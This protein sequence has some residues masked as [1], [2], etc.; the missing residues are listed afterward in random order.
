MLEI[1]ASVVIPTFNS[2]ETIERCLA[3]IR[4]NVTEYEYEIIVVDAASSDNTVEIARK[5]ADKVLV[6]TPFRINRD[7]GV[8]VAK[9]DIICFT[10]SDC[11]VPEDWIDKLVI[12]LLRLNSKDNS[13]AGVGG[14]NI[15]WSGNTSSVEEAISKTMRSPLV[16]FKARNV[17]IYKEE[18]QVQHNPPVNSALFRWV[19]EEIGGFKEEPGYPEDLDL[20]IR[21]NEKGYKLYYL[22][23]PIVQHKHKTD[24]IKFAKQMYDF[25]RKRIKVNREHPHASRFYHYG[26]LFLCF[27]LYSPLFFIPLAMALANAIYVSIRER[28]LLFFPSVF[29]FSTSFHR[30][31][32]AGE[33]AILFKDRRR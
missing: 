17:A 30:N 20:D 19:I 3:S 31:Y 25:G 15:P 12:G 24:A 9:G 18:R 23:T 28:S 32:G 26:P 11:I 7:Q 1:K 10:D 13:I 14:G 21:I 33:A 29:R 2:A 27:M 22:P 4:A 6:G 16:S 5:Y 8:R